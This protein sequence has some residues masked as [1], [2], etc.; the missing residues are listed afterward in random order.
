[1]AMGKSIPPVKGGQYAKGIDKISKGPGFFSPEPIT[2][3]KFPVT[4]PGPV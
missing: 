4:C 1:M 3:D 2:R